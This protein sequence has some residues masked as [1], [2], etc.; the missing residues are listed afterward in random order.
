MGWGCLNRGLRGLKD[1]ADSAGGVDSDAQD[2]RPGGVDGR[3]T[4]E[5]K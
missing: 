2:E 4:T 1:Y 3:E 5:E